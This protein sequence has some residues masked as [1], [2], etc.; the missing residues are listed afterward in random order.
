MS[1]N[2]P[3][4]SIEIKKL[5][6]QW[7]KKLTDHAPV[8]EMIAMLSSRS[9]TM[10]FPEVS[11]TTEAD[12]RNWYKTVTNKFF[13][14]VHEVKTLDITIDG[15]KANVFLVVNWQARTWEPPDGYSKW[16]GVYAHQTWIVER[17]PEN[18]DPVISMYAVTDFDPMDGPLR[19]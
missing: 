16:E 17:D 15:P 8:E 11:F 13:D 19:I 4:K 18:G 6:F 1:L 3:L 14:Q 2:D 7:F 12:F 9:L 10:K 5:V